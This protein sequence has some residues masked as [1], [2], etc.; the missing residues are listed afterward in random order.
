MEIVINQIGI[1]F[2]LGIEAQE[3]TKLTRERLDLI[4][5]RELYGSE[6]DGSMSE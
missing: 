6:D 2:L 5:V 1:S 3:M 4:G